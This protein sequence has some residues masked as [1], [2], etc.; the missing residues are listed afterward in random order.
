[1]TF[2]V[3]CIHIFDEKHPGSSLLCTLLDTT[4]PRKRM[5]M[6]WIFIHI[7]CLICCCCHASFQQKPKYSFKTGP[8][9]PTTLEGWCWMT[10]AQDMCDLHSSSVGRLDECSL[11]EPM[12]VWR[13]LS[14]TRKTQAHPHV[15]ILCMYVCSSQLIYCPLR[16]HVVVKGR[17][18]GCLWA[19]RMFLELSCLSSNNKGRY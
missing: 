14:N 5:L 15:Q 12:V 6:I 10:D 4:D 8:D 19:T 7:W 13:I 3:F 11:E 2:F 18:H 17:K 16:A 9:G 1:M